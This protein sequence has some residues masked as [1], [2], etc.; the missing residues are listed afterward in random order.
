MCWRQ[1]RRKTKDGCDWGSCLAWSGAYFL[2][3]AA[4]TAVVAAA[5]VV[6]VT[7]VVEVGSSSSSSNITQSKVVGEQ[8]SGKVVREVS[9]VHKAFA[10]I[11]I[12]DRFTCLD[13]RTSKRP[14]Q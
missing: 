13:R 10:R 14:Y 5:V 2:F 1:W 4:A 8:Y 9:Q 12:T 6:I 7:V 3:V 11:F